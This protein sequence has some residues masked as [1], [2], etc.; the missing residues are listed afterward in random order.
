MDDL[1]FYLLTFLRRLPYFLVIATTISAVAVAVAVSLP[2][3]YVSQMRLVV[4]APQIPTELAASTVRTPALEQL[5][6]VE[7]RLLTRANML[8]IA[9]QQNVLPNIDE[10]TPDEIVRG[11][12]ARTTVQQS[13]GHNA[14]TWMTVSFEAP[15]A[16]IAAAVLNEYLTIIQEAD[17]EFR[18]GRA[19]ETL[20]FF[21]QEAE[22][23]GTE[24][25]AQGAQILA[26][27]QEN[28]NAL[29]DSLDF[30]MSNREE[31]QGGLAL[32]EREISR[33]QSQRAQ[34]L[35]LFETTGQV[36]RAPEA[37]LSRE[38]QQ[39]RQLES[40]LAETLL[41]FSEE[42]PRVKLLRSRIELLQ[43]EIATGVY[44][45]ATIGDQVIA[46]PEPSALD[47]QIADIDNE[48]GLLE[49]QRDILQSELE[50]LTETIERTPEVSI[51]LEELERTYSRLETQYASAEQRLSTAQT[52]DLI[53]SRSRGQRIAVIEQPNVPNAPTR[54]NRLLIAGGGSVFGIIAGLGLILLMELL[55]SSIQR[56][57][58]LVTRFGIS[59]LTTVPYIRTRQ[60]IFVQR[61]L[62]LLMI[63]AIVVGAPALI[64]AVHIYYLPIDLVAEKVMNR[65]GVRW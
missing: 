65:L 59:P 25:T 50:T 57:E 53:E 18:R 31:M 30:R 61:S 35:E 14:A 34:L 1:R 60:Q 12:R 40:E 39:L 49:E 36:S 23:L 8:A 62:K 21:A 33:L 48:L 47:I 27:K 16:R 54:P 20:E 19:G 41:V 55:N 64:Y 42:N 28:T 58:D 24:L 63:L 15:E 52:G 2:P 26:F 17:S 4:E 3:A 43:T 29:P 7:Q 22:R 51:A 13:S 45:P 37:V 10:M 9:R 11:M 38:E 6:I 5:Q 32:T 44:V 46:N 56:P